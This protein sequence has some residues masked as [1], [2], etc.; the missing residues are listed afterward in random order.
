MSVLTFPVANKGVTMSEVPD[1]IAVFFEIANCKQKCRGCHSP[2]LWKN[3]KPM[4]LDL[5]E[6][7]DNEELSSEDEE[8]V[9]S[10]P[11]E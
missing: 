11:E 8:D 2:E 4:S 10:E 3:A 6:G 7:G 9:D 1:K 5:E